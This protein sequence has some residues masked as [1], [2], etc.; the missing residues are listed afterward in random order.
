MNLN[1]LVIVITG[2]SKGIG[3]TLANILHK[4]GSKVIGVYNN[5]LIEAPFDTYKCDIV[6]EKEIEKLF[7]YIKDTYGVLNV[8]VNCA[9]LSIDNNFYEKSKEEFMKVLEVNLV[10]TFLMSREASKLMNNGVIINISSTNAF[11]TYNPISID[12]DASKAGINNLTKN[13]A[14]ALPN[15]KVCG[16]APNW[17]NTESVLEMDKDYLNSELKRVGQDYLLTKEEVANKIIEIIINDN[18]K[19]GTI[20]R[21]D[22]KN[23]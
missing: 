8:L 3:L 21:M 2:A 19:S 7:N 23:E 4:K 10:G 12:Y 15:I 18:I 14:L 17:V 16:L 9:S 11:D 6:N 20:I 1:D 5:T 13:L 22:G